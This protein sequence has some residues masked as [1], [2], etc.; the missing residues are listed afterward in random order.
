MKEQLPELDSYCFRIG[1]KILYDTFSESQLDILS[2][3]ETG[4]MKLEGIP[5]FTPDF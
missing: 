2:Y 3:K 4:N 1:P 5:S